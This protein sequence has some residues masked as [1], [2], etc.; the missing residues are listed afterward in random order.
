MFRKVMILLEFSWG[1][2][3]SYRWYSVFKHMMC[4]YSQNY[5]RIEGYVWRLE[6]PHS[7]Q[8]V[9][10]S[11]S[12]CLT[13]IKCVSQACPIL[14]LLITASWRLLVKNVGQGLI[15]S[16]ISFSFVCDDD[17]RRCHWCSVRDYI[18]LNI[19]ITIYYS[20]L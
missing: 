19:N 13:R 17:Q 11:S 4:L 1:P 10:W 2:S 15:K 12:S 8:D 14:S 16:L 6:L 9:H 5:G 18:V 7:P 20:I 3:S